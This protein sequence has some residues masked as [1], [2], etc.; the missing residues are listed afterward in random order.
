[1]GQILLPNQPN[2]RAIV[3]LEARDGRELR[4]RHMR[5]DDAELLERMFYKLSSETRY[6]RFFVP[7]D[8]IEEER[9]HRETQRL[10][11]IYPENE[12][13]LIAVIDEDGYEEAVA[14]ARY[15]C[16]AHREDACEGSLVIR[17]DFQGAGI[18]RQL[19]DLLVQ[20]ALA[21]GLRHM[22]L[23]THADNCG[24]IAL[25]HGLGMP[26]KGRYSTGLYEMDVQLGDGMAPFFPFTAPE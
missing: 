23:L 12:T 14:V 21:H 7:L 11:T 22:I 5:P 2:L 13:A 9:L 20:V 8:N 10:A 19:F 4:V 18:G 6:R 26:Y 15:S 24:M 16:L 3:H 17:D 25:V 1:M